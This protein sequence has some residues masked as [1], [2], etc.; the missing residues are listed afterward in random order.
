MR[1]AQREADHSH[2]VSS[3]SDAAMAVAYDGK[4]TDV[5]PAPGY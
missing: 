3:Y 2:A 5:G 4:C 1:P